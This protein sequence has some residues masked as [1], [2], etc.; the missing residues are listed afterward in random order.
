M[1]ASVHHGGL[2]PGDCVIITKGNL[3]A[4]VLAFWL[5]ASKAKRWKR[6]LCE[7]LVVTLHCFCD[8]VSITFQ[9]SAA[10]RKPHVGC[11]LSGD[12]LAAVQAGQTTTSA[13]WSSTPR[14]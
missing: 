6:L 12:F 7:C 11:D 2:Q 1:Q 8:A 14:C 4:A 13:A 3:S 10:L 5:A 9:E